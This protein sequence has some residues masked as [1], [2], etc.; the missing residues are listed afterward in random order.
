MK[1][2]ARD[3]FSVF[4]IEHAI[5]LDARELERRYLR[6]SRDSHPDHNRAK[7]SDDCAAVLA[8]AAEINDAWRTL[9]DRWRRAQALIELRA[10]AA[11]HEQKQ[12]DQMFLMQAMELAEE[13]AELDHNDAPA[14]AAL[15]ER[16][17]KAEDEAFQAVETAIQSDDLA[18]AAR[19]L[20]QSK[21]VRKARADLES[22]QEAM[23]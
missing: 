17:T 14:V 2:P 22:Q 13:V 21:Y 6:L 20:H 9:K 16:L 19:H 4:G 10:P 18:A 1:N 8:R 11:M 7:G 12:L 23:L 15:Q 5:Q 3:P